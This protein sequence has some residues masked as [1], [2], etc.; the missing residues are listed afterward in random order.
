MDFNKRK[1]RAVPAAAL[2]FLFIIICGSCFRPAADWKLVFVDPNGNILGKSFPNSQQVM[3]AYRAEEPFL[4]KIAFQLY[5]FTDNN[6]WKLISL[7]IRKPDDPVREVAEDLH[8]PDLSPGKYRINLI[9]NDKDISEAFFDIIPDSFKSC[10]QPPR[11]IINRAQASRDI[12]GLID[13]LRNQS[14]NF[15]NIT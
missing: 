2:L 9:N 11:R 13:R 5:H 7:A 6:D 12:S 10:K 4:D 8:V 15:F 3:V 14:Y 1:W